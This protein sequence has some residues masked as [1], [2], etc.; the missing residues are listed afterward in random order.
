MRVMPS[1]ISASTSACTAGTGSVK[2]TNLPGLAI[3]L[4]SC[5]VRPISPYFSPPFSTIV[6]FMS[7]LASDGSLL[8]SAFD[9]KT[10]KLTESIK[11]RSTSGPSS[12]S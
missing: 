5:G 10:G 9:I 8:T 3:S 7:L 1:A 12:N 6:D 11:P 4:V 2:T